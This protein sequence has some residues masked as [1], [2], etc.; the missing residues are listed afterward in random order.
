M[1]RD[2]MRTVLVLFA[3]VLFV[4]CAAPRMALLDVQATTD[5][6]VV[7]KAYNNITSVLIEKGFDVKVANKDLGF[8]STEYK[9]F[10][11]ARLN[12]VPYNFSLQIK[13]QV[14]TKPDSK[15]HIKL[16]PIVKVVNRAN[17]ADFAEIDLTFLTE[18]EQGQS[19]NAVGQTFLK[20]QIMFMNVLYGVAEVCGLEVEELEYTK[21]L[22]DI[23]Y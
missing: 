2:K 19:L 1:K 15:L 17:A 16:T 13:S 9:K 21:E 18:E 10:G 8:I 4:G 23:R 5:N 6:I 12:R 7:E 3:T 20:G 14:K 11:A 22:S